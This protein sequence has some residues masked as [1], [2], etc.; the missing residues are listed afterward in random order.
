MN[1]LQLAILRS[2]VPEL[3]RVR[4]IHFGGIGGAGRGG[5]ADVLAIVG[6]Q[7]SGSD[8]APIP[9][10]LQLTSLVATIFFILRPE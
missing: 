8:L 9:E 10:S 1:T 7:I 2:F 5:I 3:R 6:Y 4:H